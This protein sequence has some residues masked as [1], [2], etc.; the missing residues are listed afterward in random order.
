VGEQTLAF[1]KEEEVLLFG[2]VM[3]DAHHPD[4][5]R[6][7]DEKEQMNGIFQSLSGAGSM[8]RSAFLLE[9]V[10]GFEPYEIAWMQ[11]RSEE[12]V[13]GDIQQCEEILKSTLSP[14]D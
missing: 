3:P 8:A 12:E 13:R 5:A 10:E 6:A 1:Y 7:L 11:D 14:T 9:R 2:D 4:P